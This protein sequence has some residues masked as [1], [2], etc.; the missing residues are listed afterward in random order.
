[1]QSKCIVHEI[2]SSFLSFLFFQQV[3]WFDT[4]LQAQD[5]AHNASQVTESE[6]LIKEWLHA[7][8]KTSTGAACAN[9]L[10]KFNTDEY[11]DGVA[12]AGEAKGAK[13]KGKNAKGKGKG[14]GTAKA[15]GKT[16]KGA[17]K[18]K[19]KKKK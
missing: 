11:A 2:R 18:G 17:G 15:K 12:K 10:D 8:N 6:Q 7:N 4:K 9:D 1:M 16:K 19:A 14:K 13:G 3:R 5:L